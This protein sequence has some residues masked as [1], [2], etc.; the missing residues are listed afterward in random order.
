MTVHD[1]RFDK[2]NTEGKGASGSA[3]AASYLKD[4]GIGEAQAKK[5]MSLL[6]SQRFREDPDDIEELAPQH[7]REAPMAKPLTLYMAEEQQIL[8]SAYEAF[9]AE[10]SGIQVVGSS[11]DTS[12]ESLIGA[13]MNLN[14]RIML[15][16]VKT[17]QP[18]TVEV[19]DSV[20]ERCPDS[21]LILLSSFYEVPGIK[22]LREFLRGSSF[23][24]AY[25]LKHTVD[26]VEQLTQVVHSVA[27]GRVTLDPTIMEGIINAGESHS[28]FLK[29]LSPR[30]I[31]VLGW[32]AKG[33]R[34][35]TIAAVLGREPK[36]VERH[37]NSIYSKLDS[38]LDS[39]HPRV[40]AVLLYLKAAGLTPPD[41]V[42]QG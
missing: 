23:G 37:I 40:Y 17:L 32:M 35:D 3:G 12:S 1:G 20:H 42:Q 15:I 2:G 34:N 4:L 26:S 13:G 41:P 18:A 31:E 8:R 11:N 39:R 30:E 14:P 33:Y 9:F 10:H 16:G 36:T 29:E 38:I 22:S 24:F 6:G 27:E 25:L 19:L 28:A 21:A 7:R 5:L